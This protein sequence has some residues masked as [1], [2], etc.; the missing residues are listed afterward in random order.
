[1]RGEGRRASSAGRA[2]RA[3]TSFY[4]ICAVHQLP[5]DVPLTA[6][7]GFLAEFLDA[8]SARIIRGN[9]KLGK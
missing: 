2:A 4:S 1:M 3:T 9:D 5:A 7:P 8:R 6:D